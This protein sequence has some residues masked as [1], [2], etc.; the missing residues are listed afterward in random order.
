MH[1]AIYGNRVG[2][3]KQ[4]VGYLIPKTRPFLWLCIKSARSK[5]SISNGQY[6]LATLSKRG[7]QTQKSEDKKHA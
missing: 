5:D 3:K 1:D 4:A 7:A 2:R 6:R